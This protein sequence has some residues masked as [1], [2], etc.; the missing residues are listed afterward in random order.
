MTRIAAPSLGFELG[1]VLPAMLAIGGP[2]FGRDTPKPVW[3][4]ADDR[5]KPNVTLGELKLIEYLKE[6]PP[7]K[8]TDLTGGEVKH[9]DLLGGRVKP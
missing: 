8:D 5:F 6:K 2:V 9:D 4:N 1:E 3:V 7:V